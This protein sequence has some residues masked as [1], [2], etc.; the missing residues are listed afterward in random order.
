MIWWTITKDM[1]VKEIP[2]KTKKSVKASPGQLFLPGG[3]VADPPETIAQFPQAFQSV[4]GP[5]PADPFSGF[6]SHGGRTK[7]IVPCPVS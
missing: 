7:G 2:M 4:D 1:I 3:V 5:F 6:H